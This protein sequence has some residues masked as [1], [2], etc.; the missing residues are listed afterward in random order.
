MLMMLC[1]KVDLVLPIQRAKITTQTSKTSTNQP[2]LVVVLVIDQFRAD[3]I[4]RFSPLFGNRGF[5]RLLERGAY[6]TNAH[7]GYENTFTAVGHSTIMSGSLPSTHGIIANIWY[8][9][10][11][12]NLTTAIDDPKWPGVGTTKTVAPTKLLSTTIGD[13]LRLS[14]NFQS[15][16]IGISIKDRAAIMIAGRRGNA[17]YWMDDKSGHMASSS[18]F[19]NEL[20]SWVKSFNDQNLAD[21][22]FKQNW[23]RKLPASAYEIA[24]QDDAPYEDTWPG[25]TKTFPHIMDGNSAQIGPNF[26]KQFEATPFSNDLLVQF[27]LTTLKNESLGQGNYPDLLAISFSATDLAGH[28]FGPY[29]QEEED[30]VI[31]LD[32]ALATLLDGLDKQV[33]LNNSL[34]VLTADHGVAP[35]PEYAQAHQLP[36]LR[37][38]GLQLKERLE[39]ALTAQYGAGKYISALINHHIYLN[40]ALIAEKHLNLSSVEDFVGQQAL[41]TKGIA[42]YFTR[43]HLLAGIAPNTGIGQRV[44][45]GFNAQ[46]SGNVLLLVSPF[47][48]I[49][50][51]KDEFTGTAHGT[52]YSYDTHVPIIMAGPGIKSGSFTQACTPSDIAPTIANILKIEPPSGAVGQVLSPAIPQ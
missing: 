7:Y 1:I 8:D 49:A 18:Y 16:V 6:F 52:P 47:T 31:R 34:I 26:Y 20:P 29:S 33:G 17:A 11:Q 13:Q 28:M 22:Y 3:Y 51:D 32:D 23:E 35:I 4:A 42:Q 10:E 39:A 43:T 37:I 40:E 21:K 9:K 2:K 48:L 27:A 14:N 15:K 25:N 19:I 5:K 38:D 45:A 50:E 41:Q 46:R 12:G 30:L 36:G 24:D 44:V